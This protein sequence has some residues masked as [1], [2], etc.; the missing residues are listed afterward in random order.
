MYAACL[1]TAGRCATTA[2]RPL[3][4]RCDSIARA[5]PQPSVSRPHDYAPIDACQVRTRLLFGVFRAT[6][7]S[8]HNLEPLAWGHETGVSRYPLQVRVRL[9]T[10]SVLQLAESA[11]RDLLDYHGTF[12]RFGL[13]L[14][15][16]QAISLVHLF[17]HFGTPRQGL[18]SSSSPDSS[19]GGA[20]DAA[21]RGHRLPRVVRNGVI[22]ICDTVTEKVHG[23]VLARA[24]CPQTP[25]RPSEAPDVARHIT[26][27]RSARVPSQE[28]LSRGLLGLPQTQVSLLSKISDGCAAWPLRPDLCV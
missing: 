17:Q 10:P 3:R 19:T 4:G 11:F 9:V 23:L 25:H 27:H 7:W 2:S 12:N 1:P 5:G 16:R 28:C 14:D 21:R 8:E 6:S 15:D 24:S 26:S 20:L 13:Q 18:G 22:F